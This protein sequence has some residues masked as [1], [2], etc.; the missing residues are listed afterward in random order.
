MLN[1]AHRKKGQILVILK[2][3]KLSHTLKS[4]YQIEIILGV[5]KKDQYYF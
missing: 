2:N 4:Q 3:Q 5:M 1:I